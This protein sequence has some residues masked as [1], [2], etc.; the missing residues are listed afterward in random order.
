MTRDFGVVAEDS[1]LNVFFTTSLATGARSDLS[2]VLEDADVV[3]VKDGTVA[4]IT[5]ALTH[6]L[7]FNSDTGVYKLAIDL[8]ADSDFTTGSDWTVYIHPDETVDSVTPAA[9]ICYFKIETLAQQAQ[10]LHQDSIYGLGCVIATTTGNTTGRILLTDVL[11]AET[12][13]ASLVG[14]TL[15]VWD[16]T[17][18]QVEHVTVVSVQSARLFN[19][20]CTSDGAVMDFTVAAGDRVW[21]TGFE[22][23]RAT[24]PGRTLDTTATGAAGVDW[25]NV[26][27]QT[28]AVT[29]SSTTVGTATALGTGAVSAAALA[30][31]AVDEILDE[32]IGDSTVTFREALRLM[33]AALG[34]KAS[35][36]AT[37]TATYR[38]IADDTNRIVATVDADGNR[39]A[40]TLSL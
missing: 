18:G 22:S 37:T 27:S 29:L 23:L 11:D 9:I 25:A 24:T 31:D 39:S 5:G 35:G 20:V 38:N 17:N 32:Q 4:T 36:L 3:F 40:V 14:A 10:R 34:G 6:T 33:V 8:S 28:T 30:A 1:T 15:A 2:S 13:D 12:A 26:E 21:F 16:A 19:V 7:T